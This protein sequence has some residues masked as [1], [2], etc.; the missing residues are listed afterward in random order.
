MKASEAFAE[1]YLKDEQP[2]IEIVPREY[3]KEE[4]SRYIEEPPRDSEEPRLIRL[5]NYVEYTLRANAHPLLPP[6]SVLVDLPGSAAGQIRHDTILR[7]E[8]NEVDAVIL[9]VGNN[10]FGDDERTQRIFELVKRKV[11]QGRSPEVPHAWSISLLLI[12]MRS[13]QQQV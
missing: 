4:S 11:I 6:G 2:Y 13:I 10:R 1:Q 12:G 9:V 7:E 8:L 5:I 3:W